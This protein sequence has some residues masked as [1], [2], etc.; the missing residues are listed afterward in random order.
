MSKLASLTLLAAAVGVAAAGQAHAY[1]RT[2]TTSTATHDGHVCTPPRGDD[3]GDP[4]YWGM[5]RITYSV[6][7]DASAGVS[8]EETRA[9]ARAAFDAWMSVDCGDGPPRIEL[10]EAET[11]V[12]ALHEYN[13]DRGNAN[14]IFYQ[15]EGWNEVESFKLAITT[16]TFRKATGEIYDADMVLNTT[17]Y[18]F[19]TGDAGV[20]V[21]LRSVLTHEA[22]HFLGLAH[23]QV[24]DATM[25]DSYT[26][27]SLTLRDLAEDDR[28]AICAVYPPAP[29]ADECDAT[30]RHGASPLCGA[31]QTE[32]DPDPEP[33]DRCCCTEGYECVEGACVVPG[34]S[35]SLASPPSATWPGALL[36]SVAALALAR[37]RRAHR[38]GA[39]AGRR[40]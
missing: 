13:E 35:C 24:G 34:C 39:S 38:A 33:A 7:Q 4:L 19:T 31:D 1:C 11:A 17:N 3:S 26:M 40:A 32:L 6:Q 18:H 27:G 36:A 12:C 16:V 10:I 21:D 30:P 28:E 8:L 22:G 25:L 9:A 20:D 14:I 5:P 23:S 29:I 37:R 2:S 15:D